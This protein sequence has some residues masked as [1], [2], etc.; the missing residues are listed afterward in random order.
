MRNM[1]FSVVLCSLA[2]LAAAECIPDAPAAGTEVRA[3]SP[4]MKTS[5]KDAD[6]PSMHKTSARESSESRVD[7]SAMQ[8]VVHAAPESR[9]SKAETLSS[10]EEQPRTK[11]AMLI[12]ALAVMVTI[13]LRRVGASDQ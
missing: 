12:A 10:D 7:A 8:K 6:A 5:A 11:S 9:P 4:L 1:L 13:A 2:Q 3:G